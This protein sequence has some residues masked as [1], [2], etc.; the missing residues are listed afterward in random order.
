MHLLLAQLLLDTLTEG[1]RALGL[2]AHL[3]VVTAER[4]QLFANRT[5]AVRLSPALASVRDDPLHLQTRG[6][7]AVRVSAL[8]GMDKALNASLYGDLCTQKQN[9]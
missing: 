7:H 8:A 1:H 2:V 4:D 9:G 6:G 3:G 5:A